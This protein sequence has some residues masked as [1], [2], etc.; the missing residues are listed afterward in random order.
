MCFKELRSCIPFQSLVDYGSNKKI[1]KQQALRTSEVQPAFSTAENSTTIIQQSVRIITMWNRISDTKLLLCCRILTSK[2][3]FTFSNLHLWAKE[4]ILLSKTWVS[5]RQDRGT[6]NVKTYFT[7]SDLHLW[8]KKKD[9]LLSDLGVSRT[10]QRHSYCR[11]GI[12]LPQFPFSRAVP[13]S[14]LFSRT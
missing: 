12:C 11:D 1:K 5:E 7:F 3:Y 6:V 14:D 8:A 13:S 2:I 4:N 10:R 9:T